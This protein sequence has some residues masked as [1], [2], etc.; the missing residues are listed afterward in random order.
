MSKKLWPGIYI[1][2]R[3]SWFDF[4]VLISAPQRTKRSSMV[5]ISLRMNVI[6]IF[7]GFV[8]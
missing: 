2:G 4:R 6:V 7:M 1:R 3:K 5:H 8:L